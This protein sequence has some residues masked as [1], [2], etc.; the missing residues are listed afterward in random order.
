MSA[1]WFGFFSM[2]FVFNDEIWWQTTVL[3]CRK[4]SETAFQKGI[5]FA[6]SIFVDL[7][8]KHNALS[9]STAYS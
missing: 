7:Q 5:F 6:E 8:R 3:F 4:S 2:M 1:L 9:D